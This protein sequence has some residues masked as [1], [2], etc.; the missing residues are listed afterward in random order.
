MNIRLVN[1]GL[2]YKNL[3]MKI[4][5]LL[6]LLLLVSLTNQLFAQKT[7]SLKS[8]KY[9][10]AIGAG[11]GF[12]T[13]HGLSYRYWPKKFGCQINFAPNKDDNSSWISAGFTFLLNLIESNRTNLFLYQGNHYYYSTRENY[14]Y[15][16]NK[17]VTTT[18]S[19]INNGIGLGIGMAFLQRINFNIMTGYAFFDNFSYIQMTGEASLYYKF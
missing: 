5:K 19:Q 13:G 10:H 15:N 18:H 9:K 12:T 8:D 16:L 4:T 3:I 7:D 2:T 1:K 6:T 11:I 17:Y 14:K